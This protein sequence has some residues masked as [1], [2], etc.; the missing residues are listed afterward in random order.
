[1]TLNQKCAVLVVVP[2]VAVAGLLTTGTWALRKA[3]GGL[4]D[5]VNRQ[6]V[7]LVEGE[8]APLITTQMLPVIEHDVVLLR[9]LDE[10]MQLMLE[11]DRDMHQALIAER[12]ALGGAED[13]Y[14]AADAANAENIQQAVA[15]VEKAATAFHSEQ[16]RA[17]YDQ[18]TAAF[19]QWRTLTRSVVA[20]A[21][22]AT[23]RAEATAT[24]H[25]PAQAA[26]DTARSLLDELQGLQHEQIEATMAAIDA[27]KR[28]IDA[29][30]A[31]MNRQK[32]AAVQTSKSILEHTAATTG[33]FVLI[34]LATAALV[35]VVGFFIARGL[36]RS[37]RRVASALGTGACQVNEAAEQIAGTSQLIA[38]GASDQASSLEETSASLQQ[39]AAM[40]R[41]NA[42]NAQQANELAAKARDNAEVGDRT[43]GELSQAMEAINESANQ[44]GRIIRVIEEIAF[45][46][47]LLALNAA[48]E[49]ARAGEHGKGFAV[50]AEEVRNLARRAADAARE[51]TTLIDGSV[52]RVEAGTSVASAAVSSLRSIVKDV[53]KVAGLLDGISRA[54]SEQAQG[55]EQINTAVSQ[56]DRTTQQNAASAEE[57]AAAAEQLRAQATS[58]TTIVGEL[59]CLV[60]QTH[61]AAAAGRR[62][63]S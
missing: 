30:H 43:M 18:F 45:Q 3:S 4:D 7:G 21:Q 26:F 32:A 34:G 22:A 54:S 25:G 63:P 40:T 15:R 35:P 50:V 39:M 11:A 29:R 56:M 10:S 44:I 33:V 57:S 47:N 5:V 49:A 6:F 60:G 31:E 19:A 48:V 20:S 38:Q 23:T 62:G 17:R 42:T 24:S 13:R 2:V 52:A 61:A 51:T 37:V 59:S 14:A 1:M 36:S 12:Q 16:T 27:K 41:A 28:Q 58:L 53:S 8:I 46:T 55:V 9:A